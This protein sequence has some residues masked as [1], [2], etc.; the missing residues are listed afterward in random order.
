MLVNLQKGLG[1]SPW[2]PLA[3]LL[4]AAASLAARADDVQINE[5]MASNQGGIR[6]EDGDT[7]DWIEIHNP[8]AA[9]VEMGGWYLTDKADEP[10][11]WQFPSFALPAGSY[12]IVF[13]SGKD[14]TNSAAPLHT[15]FK[16]AKDGGFLALV[17]PDGVTLASAFAFTPQLT[18]VSYGCDPLN[19]SQTGFCAYP[20]PGRP[21]APVAAE[22]GPEVVFSVTSRTF[23]TPF[24]V[25]LSTTDPNAVIRYFVVTNW[26]SAAL[27]NVP[28][29]TCP[30]YSNPI[31]INGPAMVRA[32]SFPAQTNYF[33]GPVQSEV[34]L[35]IAEDAAQ[36][37]SLL[38]VVLF[39][40]FGAGDVPP[41]TDQFAAMMVFEPANG[42]SS[43]TNP[44][45]LVTRA[46][47]HRHG[48]STRG[49]PKPNLRL[50][51]QDEYGGNNSQPL[52]GMPA[53]SDWV[54]Y[55][56]DVYDKSSLHNPIAHELFSEMGHYTSR[57]R[58]VEVYIRRNPG[59]PGALTT[60]DYGGLYVIEE[61]IKIAKDR[62]DI[63][64]LQCSDTN[65]PD[66]T[67]GY[68]LSIDWQKSDDAGNPIPQLAAAEVSMNCLDPDY[69][70]LASPTQRVQLQY[71]GGY[72][73]AFY[74]ALYAAD[75]RD[76]G[77]GYAPCIDLS[78]WIDYHLHQ[79]FVFN[80]D[81]LRISAF[82]YKPRSGPF[83]QGPLWDFDRSFGTGA[84]GDYRGFDPWRWRSAE[85]DGGTDAF[86]AGNTFNNPWYG[87]L[88]Q[89]PDFFQKWI[90]RYQEL[91]GGIYS[92][93][94]ITWQINFLANQ[95]RQAAPRDAAR[96]AGAGQSDT[97]P[98]SGPVQGDSYRY[99]F[100]TPGTF[101]GEVQFARVWFT[102]R[103][104]FIDTNF[105]AAPRFSISGGA[106]T[107]GCTLT[108]TSQ[109]LE[110]NSLIYYTLNG[111]DPRLPGGAASSAALSALNTATITLTTNTQV[112][113][114]N[115]NPS[116]H[117][118][119]GPGNPPLSSPWSG[120]AIA[121]FYIPP[122]FQSISALP[123]GGVRLVV[124]C[125]AGL[126]CSLEASADLTTW[127]GLTNLDN[128]AGTFQF[129]DDSATGGTARFYRA[130][131]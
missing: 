56:P 120:P 34:Y 114:R 104:H 81:M 126:P 65:A 128:P 74:T 88:F 32:R 78:S 12:F 92:L 15:N 115:W 90:D 6:D 17:R 48:S 66:L 37:T 10:A 125:Q 55:A 43:M 85:S 77:K 49:D 38:P 2:L 31:A 61:K 22:F 76:P 5:F 46:V 68:L 72:F 51:M 112:F 58:F 35:Q 50:K 106:I 98:R 14:R 20:T 71:L 122:R 67:G 47:Y 13:A 129:L 121:S 80:V 59:T 36:F 7:S 101:Q 93:S 96:W 42:I 19:P 73:S 26:V 84:Y 45:D 91:R 86:N 29:L 83:V 3:A 79:V 127:L 11:K 70:T 57:T 100:P 62:V 53:D 89:D 124:S 39:D 54:F 60:A 113:A 82:F 97:S 69:Y 110:P 33:P 23:Q 52:A 87:R 130:Q 123:G 64:R 9:A 105:L 116:H 24:S 94:N 95:V 119:T 109:T 118:L 63:N 102:N 30:I 28:D 40:N 16:L 103:V 131:Q 27:T 107:S 18:D 117:N 21:N 8:G 4:I 25:A 108:L 99:T 1:D 111:T 44:P 41:T 75:W